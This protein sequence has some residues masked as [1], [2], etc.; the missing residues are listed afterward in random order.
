MNYCKKCLCPDTR[1][2]IKIGP[3]GICNACKG[4][5]LKETD[6]NWQDRKK[7]FAQ[8]IQ[9]AKK[10]SVG[11]DC[12]VPVSGG[13]DSWYQLIKCKEYGLNILAVTWKTPARTNIGKANVDRM[14]Q[15][16]NIDHI[17]YS[18]SYET[19]KK[20]MIKAFENNGDPGIPFHMGVYTIPYRLA[21]QMSIPLIIW[22]ENS[23]LEYGGT[24]NEQLTTNIEEKWMKKHGCMQGTN[25]K[26]WTDNELKEKDLAAYA[27][28]TLK[29]LR[30]S[31]VVTQRLFL[32][33]FFKWNSLDNAKTAKKYGFIYNKKSKKTGYWNFA[34]I[35]CNFVSLHHFPMWHKFGTTRILDN[36][37]IQIRYGVI[38]REEAMRI[39]KEKGLE[40]PHEDI[41]LF[42][43]FVGKDVSWFWETLEKFRNR[44]IWKKKKGKWV[45]PNFLIKDWEW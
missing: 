9:Q 15:N 37:S 40:V 12:I 18:V 22:G 36:L 14:L 19:E 1:P 35:D 2:N 43:K 38:T 20:F 10:N 42:C 32:G 31:Q 7:Q 13:K 41:E 17:D 21:V 11:Y 28:P 16:L 26:S 4:H 29:E 44:T 23:Q 33:S 6:I 25:S 34:D 45:I 5:L 39:V 8:I 30:K 3:D 27:L 24:I